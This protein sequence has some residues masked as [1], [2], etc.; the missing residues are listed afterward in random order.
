MMRRSTR[1]A[2]R[3]DG[4]TVVAALRVQLAAAF[5][6]QVHADI[7]DDDDDRR[8][9]RLAQVTCKDSLSSLF[10][11]ARTMPNR[12]WSL[13][14]AWGRCANFR[15][16]RSAAAGDD[17]WVEY[18]IAV[19]DMIATLPRGLNNVAAHALVAAVDHRLE[20][21]AA[22]LDRRR[23]VP[24]E[25]TP[26]PTVS[27]REIDQ[28][29]LTAPLKSDLSSIRIAATF[30]DRSGRVRDAI[31]RFDPWLSEAMRKLARPLSAE[32]CAEL[33][34]QWRLYRMEFLWHVPCGDDP[35]QVVVTSH[36][37]GR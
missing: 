1:A 9:A 4:A 11:S 6:M 33:V 31:L 5:E 28:R 15:W 24:H 16:G 34:N 22:G 30:D 20:R 14:E 37:R 13:V 10:G 32:R 12:E 36:R 35:T 8:A 19:A 3:V 23:K 26:D 2:A 7:T 27:P 18:E 29:E 17:T 21:A 25:S